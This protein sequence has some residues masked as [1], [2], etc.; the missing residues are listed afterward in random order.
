[1]DEGGSAESVGE[2]ACLRM[3][4]EGSKRRQRVVARDAELRRLPHAKKRTELG[5]AEE[6][7][8]KPTV[9]WRRLCSSLFGEDAGVGGCGSRRVRVGRGRPPLQL[10]PPPS[11]SDN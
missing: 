11:N 3:R 9:V 8:A 6:E 2:V 7:E 1:M 5:A 10:F 4:G